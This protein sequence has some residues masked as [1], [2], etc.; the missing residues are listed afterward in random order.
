MPGVEL[1]EL[2]L[3]GEGRRGQP[4]V[5]PPARGA[6]Q[7]L[8]APGW[9]AAIALTDGQAHDA[10]ADPA[11]LVLRAPSTS[12]L[13]AVPTRATASCAILRR[14]SFGIVGEPQILDLASTTRPPPAA[15]PCR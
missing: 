13:P 7:Q 9:V 15:A 2:G 12:C 10:P 14:P 11:T 6:G 8:T 1:R 4:P 3:Q 5:Q